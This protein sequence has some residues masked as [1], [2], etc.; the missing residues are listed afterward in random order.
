MKTINNSN[1]LLDNWIAF[2]LEWIFTRQDQK[3]SSYSDSEANVTKHKRYVYKNGCHAINREI[4]SEPSGA[5]IEIAE[6][7]VTFGYE[8]SYGNKGVFDMVD[9]QNSA[10]PSRVFLSTIK[11]R[12]LKYRYCF[13]WGS[14]SIK[15]KNELTGNWD[16]ING[17]LVVLD[18]NFH[19]HNVQSIV[20]YDKFTGIP[21]IRQVKTF[22][23]DLLKVFVKP[24][25]KSVIFRNKYKGLG[26][27]QN[28]ND[29]RT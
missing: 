9:F 14:K 27:P 12:L 19:R 7:I 23:I 29:Q 22:D 18:H 24:L 25:V 6:K 15:R 13:A 5:S 2:D 8:D 21:Y 17:D 3:E 26:L 1:L 10:D 16:G 28:H 4:T 20:R 11:E